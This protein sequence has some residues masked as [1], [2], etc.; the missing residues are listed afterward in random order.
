[1]MLRGSIQHMR[2][3]FMLI[4]QDCVVGDDIQRLCITMVH[5]VVLAIFLA[6]G[7]GNQMNGLKPTCPRFWVTMRPW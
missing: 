4:I 1:M 3:N 5:G 2:R 6:K 7:V